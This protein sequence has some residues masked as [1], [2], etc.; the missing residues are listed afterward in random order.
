MHRFFA[1]AG[2]AHL[3]VHPLLGASKASLNDAS[4]RECAAAVISHL[5]RCFA[6]LTPAPSA[7][8]P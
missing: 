2:V 7:S 8:A 6:S 1:L 3:P 5:R 4:Y